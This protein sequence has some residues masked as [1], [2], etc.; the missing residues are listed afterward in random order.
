MN[1]YL[2]KLKDLDA[3]KSRSWQIIFALIACAILWT[4]FFI[5][6]FVATNEILKY[7]WLIAFIALVFL[8]RKIQVVTGWNLKPYRYT[9]AIISVIC[10]GAFILYAAS[11]K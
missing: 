8:Q 5:G 2:N 9:F 7:G 4:L 10:L 6:Q 1:E 3:K 11:N